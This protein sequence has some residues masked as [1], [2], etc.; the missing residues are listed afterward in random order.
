M[1]DFTKDAQLA[2]P[3]GAGATPL[4][5]VEKEGM[6]K[7]LAVGA[8][9]IFKGVGDYLK[10]EADKSKAEAEGRKDSILKAYVRDESNL[11]Q[12]LESG[13]ITPAQ[14]GARSR[15]TFREYTTNYGEFIQDF[16]KAAKAIR[17]QSELAEGQKRV[18][19]ERTLFIQERSDASKAGYVFT[20]GMDQATELAQINAHK[21]SLRVQRDTVERRAA[22]AEMRAED[23]HTQ[24]M[25]ARTEKEES[26]KGVNDIA[27]SQLQA[28][29][30]FV[31]SN[32]Q[33]VKDGKMSPDQARA[34]NMERYNNIS[35]AIQ[36]VARMNPELASPFRSIFEN[37][38]TTGDLLSDPKTASDDLRN[39]LNST[40]TKSKLVLAADPNI[41]SAMVVSEIFGGNPNVTLNLTNEASNA[42]AL[43]S[44]TDPKTGAYVPQVVGNP[45][46]EKQV[47]TTLQDAIKNI[48]NAPAGKQQIVLDQAANATNT[49][50][51]QM[52]K[53]IDAGTVD[54]KQ[55]KDLTDFIASPQYAVLVNQ[56]K[57]DTV[58]A[59]QAHKVW[60]I[61]FGKV[62]VDGVNKKL[63]GFLFDPKDREGNPSPFA[64]IAIKDSIDVQ[65][66]GS[67]ITFVAK[68]LYQVYGKFQ[69]TPLDIE[70]RRQQ[71]MITELN[72]A[73]KA[74]NQIIHVG[75][76]M[77]GSINYAKY[78]EANKHLIIPSM[79]TAPVVKGQEPAPVD[80][81]PSK[82]IPTAGEAATLSPKTASMADVVRFAKE[83]NIPVSQVLQEFESSGV[84][85]MGQ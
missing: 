66:N 33:S 82:P 83:K 21:T 36:A 50:M 30:M 22:A 62:L 47:V 60:Q 78:W 69:K 41:R 76:H 39:Q 71:E 16:E 75:A 32:A 64:R 70:Y 61:T 68:P 6:S 72:S 9:S 12:M 80:N 49:L 29:Q 77:E 31:V 55:L 45:N 74:V 4:R 23:S 63:E 25:Q 10:L 15:A 51:K 37:I 46:T 28:F 8:Q 81:R 38:K 44:T 53:N 56:D 52:A 43:L 57:I 73:Q 34:L 35:A 17:G 65:F 14:A 11:A 79:F 20:P 42:L 48:P 13:Q 27:G 18:E 54:P 1:A 84:E 2:P 26:F 40:M 7:T 5:P 3:Q 59:S 67:G 58:A 85:V 19:E 24:A